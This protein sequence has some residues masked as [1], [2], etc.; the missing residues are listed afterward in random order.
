M[1]K[2]Y[3]LIEVIITLSIIAIILSITTLGFN[4]YKEQVNRI[5]AKSLLLEIKSLLSLSKAYCRKNNINGNI[6]L[7]LNEK[8]INFSSDKVMSEFI[9]FD[10][11]EVGDEFNI[12]SNFSNSTITIND[13]GFITKAG[14]IELYIG[15]QKYDELR[16]AVGMDIIGN[17][18]RKVYIS[19]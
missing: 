10:K 17:D 3:T 6:Y 19:Q 18:E 8:K 7:D 9:D 4:Y 1:K 15:N 13:E 12:K 5:E 16:I 11:V 2:G 14:T